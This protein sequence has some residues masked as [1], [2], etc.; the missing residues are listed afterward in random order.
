MYEGYP[1]IMKMFEDLFTIPTHI[2]DSIMEYA[3]AMKLQFP[4]IAEEDDM[5]SQTKNQ[6]PTI[7]EEDEE[8]DFCE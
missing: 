8:Y 6:L 2:E 4:T 1:S 7:A 3:T 5:V